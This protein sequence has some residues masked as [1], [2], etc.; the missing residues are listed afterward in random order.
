MT[1]SLSSC[2]PPLATSLQDGDIQD[3]STNVEVPTWWS[4]QLLGGP[5]HS[6]GFDRRLSTAPL[7]FIQLSIWWSHELSGPSRCLHG[8]HYLHLCDLMITNVS[9]QTEVIRCPSVTVA[10][11]WQH[12]P[13]LLWLLQRVR[14][15]TQNSA[16]LTYPSFRC[17][18]W[19][20]NHKSKSQIIW[21]N[22]LYQCLKSPI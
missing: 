6:G 18:Q 19:W 4:P 14:C 7:C 8:T 17:W 2:K 15:Q 16:L 5:L 11:L 9:A 10:V 22:D 1:T 3:G 20:A 12:W 21:K 13:A